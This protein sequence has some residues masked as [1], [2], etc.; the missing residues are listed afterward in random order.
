MSILSIY[1]A[2]DSYI[3]SLRKE[4]GV[5]F[6][7]WVQH[8]KDTPIDALLRNCPN[9]SDIQSPSIVPY[10]NTIEHYRIIRNI[11][12][13][14]R[15]GRSVKSEEFFEQNNEH[16]NYIRKELVTTSAPN[17]I[18]ELKFEDIKVFARVVLHATDVINIAFTPSDDLIANKIPAKY[19]FKNLT[20]DPKR[21]KK[22]SLA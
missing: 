12:A 10:L 16:L 22:A 17:K 1:S 19:Q 6:G 4:Y 11:V 13:H 20:H 3:G 18:T 7:E 8:K 15:D 14:P 9:Q 5:F 2:F 21:R